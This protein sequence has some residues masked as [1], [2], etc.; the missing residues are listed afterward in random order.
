MK[1]RGRTKVGSSRGNPGYR[2]PS[3]FKNKPVS[4]KNVINN[5]KM[6]KDLKF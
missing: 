6:K 3:F 5:A 2:T 4:G 1:S